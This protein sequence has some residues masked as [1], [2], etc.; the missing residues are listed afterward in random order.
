MNDIFIGTDI[1]S[2]ERID[3]ILSSS[4]R[5]NFTKRVYTESEMEYC[6][7]KPNPA[8]HF[9]GRF[10]AKEAII[11]ALLSS[12]S[13]SIPMQKIEILA[14]ENGEPIVHFNATIIKFTNCKVSISHTDEFAIAFAMIFV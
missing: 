7:N 12:G 6:T 13:D 8:I 9:A 5:D 2:V 11:K 4:K 1:A 3:S 10:A 14:N